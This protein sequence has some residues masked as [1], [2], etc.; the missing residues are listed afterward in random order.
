MKKL[1]YLGLTLR[2]VVATLSPA[3]GVPAVNED[4]RHRLA[5]PAVQPWKFGSETS[6]LP[7]SAPRGHRQL[8]L[9]DISALPAS[10]RQ[11]LNE[12]DTRIDRIIRNVCRNC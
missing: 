5:T 7:W 8:R 2:L 12:E 9:R 6:A 3:N 1:L 4:V 10:A 11:D